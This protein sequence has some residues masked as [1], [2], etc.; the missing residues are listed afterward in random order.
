MSNEILYKN[1]SYFIIGLCMDIHNEL[2][3]GFNE[4]VYGDTLEIELRDNGVPFKREV[5]FK[6]DYKGTILNHKY[7]ADFVI[8]NKIIM[9]LKAIQKLTENHKKTS[10]QLSS[11]LKIEVR[12]ASEFR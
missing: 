9:E 5:E 10:N 6:I 4:K 8:D 7:Y 11:C 2:G 12:P 3:K 1:E